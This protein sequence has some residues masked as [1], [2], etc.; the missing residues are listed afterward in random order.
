MKQQAY[1]VGTVGCAS[2]TASRK[3]MKGDGNYMKL[4]LFTTVGGL[5]LQKEKNTIENK[6]SGNFGFWNIM[7]FISKGRS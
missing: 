4:Q 1:R 5:D 6:Y 7:T 3:A 2:Q